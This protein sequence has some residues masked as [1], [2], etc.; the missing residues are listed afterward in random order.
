[1]PKFSERSLAKLETCDIRLAR[2]FMKVVEHY[3]CSVLCGHRPQEIQD[4]AFEHGN[5]KLKWPDSKHNTKPSL[6]VDLAPYPIDWEDA[7]RFAH[8]AGY[9][10][11]IADRMGYA[12]RWGG[13]WDS[14]GSTND[15]NFMDLGHF[16][17]L[18]V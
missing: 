3:D 12:I 17:I 5:S 15:Q 7:L 13:D 2:L 9:V 11:A 6:A 16:E 1:M 4:Y 18:D 10:K 14:D 8:F